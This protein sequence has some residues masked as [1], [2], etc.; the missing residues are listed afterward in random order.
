[1]KLLFLFLILTVA[2]PSISTGA[3]EEGNKYSVPV[4]F[5][6]AFIGDQGINDSAKA[7]LELI[8]DEKTN[9][10]LHQGDFDYE[11]DPDAWID[12]IDTIL[13]PDFPYFA[14]VGNVD[15]PAWKG[16]GGWNGWRG[17]GGWN[18]WGGY[19]S[20]LESRLNRIEGASCT[21]DLGVNSVCTYKG[22]F[23]LLS[24]IGTLGFDHID[25]M[26]KE[27]QRLNAKWKICSWHKNQRLMQVGAMND[28]V[29]W[30]AYEECRLAGAFVATGHEHSYSRTHLMSSF[31]EQTIGHL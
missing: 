26:Q 9:M 25:Y 29:G 6:I 11:S 24:G 21:G 30:R 2:V 22:I 3:N 18:G 27:L 23:F 17:W 12:Q 20:K 19:Q 4:N 1:M 16:W 8:R 7:V 13:G 31:E 15:V 14:S 5:K 10:V 28:E